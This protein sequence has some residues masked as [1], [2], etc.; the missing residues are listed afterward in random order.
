MKKAPLPPGG[1]HSSP[2]SS[3]SHSRTGAPVTTIPPSPSHTRSNSDAAALGQRSNSD[4]STLSHNSSAQV[5]AEHRSMSMSEE[6]PERRDPSPSVGWS[7]AVTNGAG[8][9]PPHPVPAPRTIKPAIPNK[10][11]GISRLYPEKFITFTLLSI[12]YR[13]ASMRVAEN[14]PRLV[15]DKES[16]NL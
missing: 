1:D 13:N 12:F 5:Q 14:Q 6:R 7:G 3:P 10:P 8:S 9:S 16:T 15:M 11:E 4:A 2:L